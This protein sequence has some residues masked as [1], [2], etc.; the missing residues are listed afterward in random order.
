MYATL[1]TICQNTDGCD[2]YYRYATELY[3]M[4]LWSQDFSVII[5]RGIS[6]PGHAREVVDGL[7]V[8][9]KRFIY[10]LMSTVQLSGA[11]SYETKMVMHTRTRT[12]DVSLD[13]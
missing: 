1:S 2:E 8:I 11:K 13:K 5:D 3:L 6:A 4:S 12:Y 10:Q 9:D 7:K